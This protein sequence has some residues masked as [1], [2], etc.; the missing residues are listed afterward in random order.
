MKKGIMIAA[1][2][3][4]AGLAGTAAAEDDALIAQAKEAIASRMKD[5]GSVQFR[6]VEHRTITTA[7]TTKEVVCG[8][9]NA[10]NMYGGYVG[11]TPFMVIN[12][13]VFVRNK[14]IA[15]GFDPLRKVYCGG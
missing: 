13:Q 1:I 3:F 15:A 12:G 2:L 7:E 14:Q 6:S 11:F 4:A 9:V 5:P 8:E 10:K